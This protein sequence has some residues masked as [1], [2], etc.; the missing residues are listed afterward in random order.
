MK[1]MSIPHVVV[2][3]MDMIARVLP[4]VALCWSLPAFALQP[5]DAFVSS[6]LGHS[7]DVLEAKANALQ[8]DAQADV[9]L[10]RVLPGV[11]ARGTYTRNQ[12]ESVLPPPFPPIVVV[13]SYA[14]DGYGTITIPL[15]DVAGWTRA[16]AAK[17]GAGAAELQLAAARLSIQ[18][19]VAQDYY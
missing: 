1:K 11:S 13:P 12:Y 8:Q 7:P 15:I 10:G 3:P 2:R 17:I 5:L 9:A 16:S 14:W 19:Q 4:L 6:A 18:A